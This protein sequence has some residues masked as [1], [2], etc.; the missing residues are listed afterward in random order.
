MNIEQTTTVAISLFIFILWFFFVRMCANA[1][2]YLRCFP[3]YSSQSASER[4]KRIVSDPVF[5]NGT[6]ILHT[7]T[8]THTRVRTMNIRITFRYTS[9]TITRGEKHLNFVWNYRTW[10]LDN[11]WVC[12]SLVAS[13]EDAIFIFHFFHR[14]LLFILCSIHSFSSVEYDLVRYSIWIIIIIQRDAIRNAR[15]FISI[16]SFPPNRR[17]YF[18]FYIQCSTIIFIVIV[19]HHLK[20][21]NNGNPFSAVARNWRKRIWSR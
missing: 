4:R 15:N 21:Q 10:S 16:Q 1:F 9:N 8:H 5:K 11:L 18:Y 7:N 13:R 12:V 6:F 14:L 3:F 2:V 20:S 17:D 19:E